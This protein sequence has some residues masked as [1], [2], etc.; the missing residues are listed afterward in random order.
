LHNVWL[1]Q[2]AAASERVKQL[3]DTSQQIQDYNDAL[4]DVQHAFKAYEDKLN[5]YTAAA[6]T[7]KD[8]KYLDKVK[9]GIVSKLSI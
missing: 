7:S 4:R 5:S 1:S 8:S 2:L 3:E 9:V 6:G